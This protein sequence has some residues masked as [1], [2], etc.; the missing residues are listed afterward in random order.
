M[1]NFRDKQARYIPLRDSW[2]S[3]SPTQAAP[4]YTEALGSKEYG[5]AYSTARDAKD[6]AHEALRKI[7][8]LTKEFENGLTRPNTNPYERVS[9]A[10]ENRRWFP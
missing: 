1:D 2:N 9:E 10:E 5:Q 7:D 8:R 6:E 3:D 4:S